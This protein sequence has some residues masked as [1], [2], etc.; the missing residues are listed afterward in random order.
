MLKRFW[1]A[2]DDPDDVELFMEALRDIDQSISCVSAAN[3]KD[4][5]AKLRSDLF[6]DPELI[7]LD[8]NMPEMN[9]WECLSVL[10]SDESLRHI[11]V[12]MYSTSSSPKNAHR[13]LELGAFCFYGKPNNFLLLKEFLEVLIKSPSF[14]KDQIMSL[15]GAKGKNQKVFIR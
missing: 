14:D 4:L 7:F 12:V 6:N 9:G 11:P 1:L 5:I 13:A 3:G 8:I 15:M 10:K 2:E